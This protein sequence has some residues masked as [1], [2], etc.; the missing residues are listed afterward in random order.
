MYYHKPNWLMEGITTKILSRFDVAYGNFSVISL[1][2]ARWPEDVFL[3]YLISILILLI[4]CPHDRNPIELNKWTLCT[5]VFEKK[6][7]LD[8]GVL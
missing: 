5:H 2:R 3:I 4:Y 6:K 7:R 1:V 8:M